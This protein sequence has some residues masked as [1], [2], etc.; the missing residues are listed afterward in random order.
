MDVSVVG[1]EVKRCNGTPN[2]SRAA[3][4]NYYDKRASLTTHSFL[5]EFA[6]FIRI[7][8]PVRNVKHII[9]LIHFTYLIVIEYISLLIRI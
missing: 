8:K 2:R 4:Y 7:E 6:Y 5:S 9:I 1:I 3:G